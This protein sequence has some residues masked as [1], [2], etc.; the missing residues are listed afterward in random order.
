[1]NFAILR[2]INTFHASEKPRLETE[3]WRLKAKVK[4]Q[5]DEL[6]V[7]EWYL[8]VLEKGD[9]REIVELYN[10]E[11]EAH[12][13]LKVKYLRETTRL[14]RDLKKTKNKL[15]SVSDKLK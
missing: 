14:D 8:N 2:A 4:S 13:K 10:K 15:K 7:I 3:N 6:Q 9:T 11:E 12:N 1:M 5:D